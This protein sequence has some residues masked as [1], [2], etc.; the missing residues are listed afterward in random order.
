MFYGWWIVLIAFLTSAFAGATVWYGFTAYFD[1]L[2]NEFG[3]SYTAISL[4]ASFRGLE[5]GLMDIFVGL[6]VDRFGGRRIVLAGSIIM[7]IGYLMLSQV[8]TLT[9]F[10]ISFF[11]IFI[12]ASG[13][14]NVVL[15]QVVTRWFRKRLGL[16]IGLVSAGFGVSGF[17]LP[18]IVYLLDIL[19]F[20]LVFAVVGLAAILIGSFAALFLRSRPEDMGL[21]PDGAPLSENV[22]EP[23]TS[24]IIMTV[25]SQKDHSIKEAIADLAFWITT[26]AGLV[27]GLSTMMISTHV[28]PYLKHIGYPR[29][30]SSLVAMMIPVTSIIGRLGIGWISD[31]VGRKRVFVIAMLGQTTGVVLFLF[32][33]QPFLLV[34]SVI[35]FSISY[36]GIIV[37]RP[38]VF[39]D[40]YGRSYIG[41]L[42]G[43]S[44]GIAS[45]GSIA[46][47]LLAGWIF[48]TTNSYSL[49]W[50]LCSVLLMVGVP[51]LLIMKKPLPR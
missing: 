41:S 21:Y 20:R 47:P 9:T 18:A 35:L 38:A 13:A 37:L 29:Y 14:S 30:M 23:I 1:P 39:Q 50:V 24:D 8:N 46:G 3:W 40:Y 10:Y 5:V 19:G 49:A 43:L 44:L 6:L 34:S 17:A 25:I 4:A 28:M 36:G 22:P 45:L 15:F 7:G 26:Y 11:I 16:V 2:V 33:Q 48:D 51:L 27:T 32:A 12:G 42:L 31:L